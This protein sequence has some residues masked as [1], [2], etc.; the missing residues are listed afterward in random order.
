MCGVFWGDKSDDD[1]LEGVTV[2]AEMPKVLRIR[3]WMRV[4][5]VRGL[6]FS[7]IVVEFDG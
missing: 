6:E 5:I 1:R 7:V 3:R 2:A 4:V